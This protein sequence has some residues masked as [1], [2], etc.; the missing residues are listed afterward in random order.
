MFSSIDAF[1]KVG[2]LSQKVLGGLVK[3]GVREAIHSIPGVG[4]VVRLVEEL[5][6]NGA[7][8]LIQSQIEIPDVKAAG[9]IFSDD[10][11]LAINDWLGFLQDSLGGLE[12][13]LTAMLE[14]QSSAPWDKIAELVEQALL[15][16]PDLAEEFAK[17]EE[18]LREQTLSLHRMEEILT[19]VCHSQ[20][21][22]QEGLKEIKQLLIKSPL[23][24]DY[25]EFKRSDPEILRLILEADRLILAG[26]RE[27]GEKLYIQ[28]L[29]KRGVHTDV[30]VQEYGLKARLQGRGKAAVTVLQRAGIAVEVI[31]KVTEVTAHSTK[32]TGSSWPCLPRGF[33]IDR[34][35]QVIEEVGRGGMASVYKV[36]GIEQK[37]KGKIF[38]LKVPSPRFFEEPDF[39]QRFMAEIDFS[40]E[41]SKAAESQ[42]RISGE[43]PAIVQ[44]HGYVIFDDPHTKKELYGLVMD[45]IEGMT[46][47]AWLE[48]RQKQGKKL[49]V[50][51]IQKIVEPVCKALEF[52]HSQQPAILHRDGTTRNILMGEGVWLTDFGIGR[53]MDEN[54]DGYTQA[55]A[56][57][58][59]LDFLPEE[60]FDPEN[61]NEVGPH[62]DVFILGKVLK[63]LMTFSP[64]GILNLKLGYPAHWLQV[65]ATATSPVPDFR[66]QTVREFRE[67]LF[68]AE[69]ESP[70]PK[71]EVQKK[72][73]P[74]EPVTNKIGMKLVPVPAGTFWMGGQAG[75]EGD[76]QVNI[77]QPFWMGAFPVTQGQWQAVMGNNPSH[78]SRT[79]GGA[80]ELKKFSDADLKD[81]P[82]EQVSWEE[83]Q[84]FI[85]KLNALEKGSGRLYYLP[86]E[87]EW[88]YACRGAATSRA[89][90][91]F[92]FYLDRATNDLSSIEANFNGDCPDGTG[93]K[94]PY[95]RRTTKVGSYKPNR[96]GLYDMHGNVWE[97]CSDWYD[98]EQKL[99]VLR[100]G[101]WARNPWR[102]GAAVR[103]G[104]GPG[105][106]VGIIGFRVCFRLD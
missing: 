49:T 59:S 47:A 33:K 29:L 102:A 27:K 7:V 57:V 81:F 52:A 92:S 84:Q 89:D 21:G 41:L 101:S 2:K 70:P 106:R 20:R 50:D 8:R 66:Y 38:A 51:E 26:E 96:L 9:E 72:P 24:R 46:L 75:K 37:N 19:Q 74:A 105:R 97:W 62:T 79:G 10:Q 43:R 36:I 100:G 82:V 76:R 103:Y 58:G 80:A 16:Q 40:L 15:D 95:L 31:D 71:V 11:L 23:M 12:D 94:G 6:D 32:P 54:R 60:L 18:Q 1:R 13:K 5:A 48:K 69:A 45:F 53:T 83:A 68:R 64:R 39:A 61:R 88:E 73:Q 86:S 28:V 55:G 91:A 104:N 56:V 63:A 85:E 14:K 35:Y 44:T 98:S 17:V 77:D 90:C 93:A 87:A 3:A 99:R 4:S 30:I 25:A 22:L 78:F 67:A 34:R 42:R 65:V